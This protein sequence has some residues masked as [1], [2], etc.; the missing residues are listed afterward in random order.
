MIK[1]QKTLSIGG[2][3]PE[4]AKPIISSNDI[5]SVIAKMKFVPSDTV[6]A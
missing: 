5:L 4:A 1:I 3:K 2:G 6:G